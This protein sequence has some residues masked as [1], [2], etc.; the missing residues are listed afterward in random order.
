[1]LEICLASLDGANY[2]LTFS[3]GLGTT[4]VITQLLSAG[5]HVICSDDVYGGTNR[6]FSQVA[7]KHGLEIEFVDLLDG[8]KVRKALKPNTK[9]GKSFLSHAQYILIRFLFSLQLIWI[10]TP[11]NP[12]LKVIDIEEIAKIAHSQPGVSIHLYFI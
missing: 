7:K 5:D 12:I 2:A 4:T 3:S 11:T 10:E 8:N 6:L 9:V 1:M